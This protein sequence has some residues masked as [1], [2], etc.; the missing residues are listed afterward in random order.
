MRQLAVFIIALLSGLGVGSG[1]L[2]V[3]YL[4]LIEN[5]E[6]LAAQGANLVFFILASLSSTLLSAKKRRIP[7]LAVILMAAV[8]ISGSL[9]GSFT[10][11]LIPAAALRKI[12]G[13]TLTCFGVAALKKK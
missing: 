9:M 12:F 11:T 8:G 6:Q 7:L 4:T 5:T 2:L 1:G 13:A 3:I 10:A